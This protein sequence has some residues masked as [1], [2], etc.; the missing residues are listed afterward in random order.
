MQPARWFDLHW[1]LVNCKP[2]NWRV[3]CWMK[4]ITQWAAR[5]PS[6]FI[7]F[8]LFSTWLSLGWRLAASVHRVFYIISC[9]PEMNLVMFNTTPDNFFPCPLVPPFE[10]AIA[11][12]SHHGLRQTSLCRDHGA[13][14]P[15]GRIA[16]CAGAH[17]Q[18]LSWQG[19]D[20][21]EPRDRICEV[22]LTS[23]GFSCF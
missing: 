13:A 8:H 21:G 2:S 5:L 14:T 7:F 16:S 6:R 12:H 9:S 3:W 22:Q 17:G 10:V 19:P 18:F 20:G 1:S 23:T 4:P 11:I 15:L